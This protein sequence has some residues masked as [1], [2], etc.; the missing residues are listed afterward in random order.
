VL[1]QIGDLFDNEWEDRWWPQPMPPEA[2][3]TPH[4]LSQAAAP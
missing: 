4:S 2:R 1:Q 3:A